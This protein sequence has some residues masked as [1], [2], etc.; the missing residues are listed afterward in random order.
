[1]EPGQQFGWCE[2]CGAVVVALKL[3]WR[4]DVGAVAACAVAEER[5]RIAEDADGVGRELCWAGAH[6]VNAGGVHEVDDVGRSAQHLVMDGVLR[7]PAGLGW[8]PARRTDARDVTELLIACER[9]DDGVADVELSDVITDWRRPSVDLETMT[10]IVFD[11]SQLVAFAQVIMGRAE[12][13]VLPTD[14]GRGI[15]SALLAF[16]WHVARDDGHATVGQTVSDG[17]ID[18]VPLFVR[19]GYTRRWTSWVL[20][21]DVR[22]VPSPRLPDGYRLG[23]FVPDEHGRAAFEVIDAAFNEWPDRQ[24]HDFQDWAVQTLAHERFVASA[25]PII[26]HE[27]RLVGVAVNFDYG[28]EGW[29]HQLAVARAHRGLGLGRALLT[30]SFE[31]HR[32]AGHTRVGLNTD[33]RTDALALYEHVGMRVRRS[34]TH[35]SKQLAAG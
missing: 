27:G 30:A 14:R 7:L 4:E 35:W 21:I 11:G 16:T 1:M 22:D 15:G 23:V 13:A 2:R 26:V 12:A 19:H 3:G 8:R 20:S 32:R 31:R 17:R 29:V 24:G 25:S 28:T 10:A 5:G 33:S 6:L 9:F 34:Y 18:A